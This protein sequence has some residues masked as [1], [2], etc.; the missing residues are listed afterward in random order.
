MHILEKIVPRLELMADLAADRNVVRDPVRLARLREDYRYIAG[1]CRT[2]LP[3]LEP[4]LA[5]LPEELGPGA[6]VEDRISYQMALIRRTNRLERAV[7]AY[8]E[9]RRAA[10]AA[11][12]V[13]G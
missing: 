9:Q 1:V 11:R 4:Q 5:E 12:A 2:L 3:E 8:L 13:R 6:M 10:T 7:W